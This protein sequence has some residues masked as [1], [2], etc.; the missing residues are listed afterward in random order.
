[1]GNDG[2]DELARLIWS[3]IENDTQITWLRKTFKIS[4]LKLSYIWRTLAPTNIFSGKYSFHSSPHLK[5]SH[6][7]L[8]LS[9]SNLNYVFCIYVLHRPNHFSL[10]LEIGW[11]YRTT[12]V[13]S[14]PLYKADSSYENLTLL[15]LTWR[16]LITRYVWASTM[17]ALP[18]SGLWRC[19]KGRISKCW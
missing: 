11:E 7:S 3:P 14:L 10:T 8:F 6:L 5:W 12:L 19:L 16:S 17:T 9:S 13:L 4:R 2:I 18:G 1:M 15:W